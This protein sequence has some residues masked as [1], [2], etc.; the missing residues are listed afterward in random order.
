M[1]FIMMDFLNS[2][3]NLRQI[4]KPCFIRHHGCWSTIF[5]PVC[6]FWQVDLLK[7]QSILGLENRNNKCKANQIDTKKL[8]LI[9]YRL[10]SIRRH[11]LWFCL[12]FNLWWIFNNSLNRHLNKLIKWIQ[13]LSNKAFFFKVRT[14]NN[15]TCF[16]P[17]IRCYFFP[18][19]IT[20]SNISWS[21]QR[22]N[23]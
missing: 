4:A 15:P 18:F 3:S 22:K 1:H 13:L 10:F 12:Q 6:G 9:R 11:V 21:K 14:Y 7:F 16:L 23:L 19:I 5:L 8:L 17:Q 2:C 20:I